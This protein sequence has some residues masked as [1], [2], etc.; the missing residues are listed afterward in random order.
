MQP[1]KS[2]L[3]FNVIDHFV[4]NDE[5]A[6]E[7]IY[8]QCFPRA[9]DYILKNSGSYEQA[10]DVYQESF[11]A[12]WRNIKDGKFNPKTFDDISGY[13]SIIVRNKWIDNL[14]SF[15]HKKMIHEDDMSGYNLVEEEWSG[16]EKELIA[17]IKIAFGKLGEKCRN[18]LTR[19]YYEKQRIS[20]IASELNYTEATVRNNK[21]RCIRKLRE[22]VLAN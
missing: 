16:D 15:H 10:L 6:L 3:P 21:Y 12:L 19:Y 2:R 20:A 11:L 17:L 13:L 9:R 5:T 8:N 4:L 18:L 7:G 1:S 22:I 14:R